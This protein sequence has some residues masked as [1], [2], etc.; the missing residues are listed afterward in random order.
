MQKRSLIKRGYKS[1]RSEKEERG[2]EK[3][4]NEGIKHAELAERVPSDA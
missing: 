1:R 3:G 4:R 2:K